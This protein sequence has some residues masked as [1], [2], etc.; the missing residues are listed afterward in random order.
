MSCKMSESPAT[1]AEL[2][3]SRPRHRDV[4]VSDWGRVVRIAK[5]H[6]RDY[7]TLRERWE[8]LPRDA[9]GEVSEADKYDWAVDVVAHSVTDATG[10]LQFLEGGPR[11]WLA[12]EPQA[13]SE[14]LPAVMELSGLGT[15]APGGADAPKKNG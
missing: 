15:A 13:V 1:A 4:L 8:A 7:I 11:Q 9:D 5:L 3:G 10:A 14:L 6:V 2:M 12:G